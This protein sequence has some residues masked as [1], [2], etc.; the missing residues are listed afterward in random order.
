MTT[1]A[2]EQRDRVTAPAPAS[3]LAHACDP[4]PPPGD[5]SGT[6]VTTSPGRRAGTRLIGIDAARGVAL[7]GMIAVHVMDPVAADGQ[8]PSLAWS[9]AA[10]K[11]AALFA[12][13]AGVGV[14]FASGR[15]ER[16]RGRLWAANAS[17]L[18]V[19]ALLI[20]VVGL[21][22][23]AVVPEDLAAVILP[24][25]A[26]LFLLAIPLLSLSVRALVL[27]AGAIALG[28]PVLSHLLRSGSELVTAPNTTFGQ[29]AS[30][31]AGVLTELA[32]TGT[33]PALPWLAYLCVG[34]AV[35]RA[36]LSSRRTVVTITLTGVALAVTARVA[37][38][39]LLDVLGGRADLEEVALRS[40]TG[41]QYTNLLVW[42]PTGVTPSDSPWWLAT[43]APHSSTPLDLL[44]TIGVGLA[45]L[46]VCLL[47]GRMTTGLLRP[48]A[49]AG[50]MTLTLYSLHLLMLSS[51]FMPD[52][53]LAS[54]L[55]QV[56]VLVAFAF[57]WSSA[58]V[59]G[60]LEDL[61]AQATG[62][63]RRR[64]LA[65]RGERAGAGA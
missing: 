52:D 49:V 46:G 28:M 58:H 21:A 23:G 15:R 35:G 24:Y 12:L 26:L 42:G 48:L 25:Y 54:L 62:A 51:P 6:P 40:L 38:W 65:G 17:S 14:A 33:Y 37:S 13:L 9:L 36:A 50:S 60:P 47:V 3:A 59:R 31:P 27:V 57:A 55:L 44:F 19:R 7:L 43:V 16:P 34:L 56:L 18:V 22:L 8:N 39:V 1:S 4:A 20:G 53:D 41:E 5:A 2:E 61:V 32:L 63:V 64:V 30:D 29:L 45:V 11:S 10:G